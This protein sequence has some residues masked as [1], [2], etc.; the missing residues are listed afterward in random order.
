[1]TSTKQL[2]IDMV[3]N[4]KGSCNCEVC[5]EESSDGIKIIT[6]YGELVEC[7]FDGIGLANILL[8]LANGVYA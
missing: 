8:D 6:A 7:A 4:Y 2:V 5:I 3:Y 1:M